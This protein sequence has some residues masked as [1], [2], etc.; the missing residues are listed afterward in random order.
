[1]NSYSSNTANCVDSRLSSL[2]RPLP[3]NTSFPAEKKT[4]RHKTH[5]HTHTHTQRERERE[6]ERE[7]GREGE[8]ERYML[9]K[10]GE[11]NYQIS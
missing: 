3:Q 10:L 1:V 7:G 4:E 8:R 2:S 5:T 9:D 6:R 11:N